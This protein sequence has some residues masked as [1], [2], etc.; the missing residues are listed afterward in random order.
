[1]CHHR[2]LA[3]LTGRADAQSPADVQ[4]PS[5]PPTA[6]TTTTTHTMQQTPQ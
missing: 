4:S 3:L 1:V 2:A 6:V 5:L